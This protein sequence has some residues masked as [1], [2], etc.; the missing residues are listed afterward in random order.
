MEPIVVAVLVS[1]GVYVIGISLI[2]KSILAR[3]TPF[4]R[5]ALQRLAAETANSPDE[6]DDV[7]SIMR[8]QIQKS[9]IITRVFFTLP[10]SSLIYPRLLKAGL[11]ENLDSFFT[12]LLVVMLLLVY[13][14]KSAGLWGILLAVVGTYYAAWMYIKRKIRKRNEAFLLAFPD[15]LDMIVRS[16]RSGYPLNTSVRMVSENMQAP[17]STEFKQVADETAYGSTLIEALQRLSNRIDEPDIRFFVVVLTVQQEVGGNLAEVLS[18]LSGIIRKRKHL[19][20]KIRAL[21]SEGRATTWVLSGL[22]LLVAGAIYMTTP[23]HLTPFFT[24]TLGNMMLAS[25]IGIVLFGVAI[26]RKMVNFEA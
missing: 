26:V 14:L 18:N 7:T 19:R 5:N 6:G 21:T 12:F 9:N 24:S 10:G 23:S 11:A 16:V 20:M 22:P 25:A 4:T 2:P 3:V 15:A 1:L 13:M 17:V 8:E